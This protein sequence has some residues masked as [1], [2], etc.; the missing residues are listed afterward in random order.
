MLILA[1]IL[2]TALLGTEV[3][4]GL[5]IREYLKE[6]SEQRTAARRAALRPK[7]YEKVRKSW[8]IYRNRKN[9]WNI[10]QK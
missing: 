5:Y 10:I 2:I 8:A 7:A 4:C 3:Y 1:G 6:R 9:L